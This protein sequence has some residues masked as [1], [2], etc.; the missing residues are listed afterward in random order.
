MENDILEQ[1]YKFLQETIISGY[2]VDKNSDDILQIEEEI[3]AHLSKTVGAY[4][5]RE[6]VDKLEDLLIDLG[7]EYIKTDICNYFLL[8]IKLGM[9]ANQLENSTI[10][11]F[12]DIINSDDSI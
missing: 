10:D 11:K 4:E 7:Q 2:T 9:Q 1:F 5:A 6:L 8:G 12:L 3:V